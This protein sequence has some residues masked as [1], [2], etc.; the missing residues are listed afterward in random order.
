MDGVYVYKRAL[1]HP[2]S[3]SPPVPR[4][5]AEYR[6]TKAF[7][8]EAGCGSLGALRAALVP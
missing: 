3:P 7:I 1:P 6:D 4:V 5:E 8:T 2:R